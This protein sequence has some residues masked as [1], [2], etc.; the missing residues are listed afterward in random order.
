MAEAKLIK[1]HRKVNQSKKV[2]HR[3]SF[4]FDDEGQG[5]NQILYNKIDFD[6]YFKAI[7]VK[8]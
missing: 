3:Q 4:G 1:F 2:Y 5:H 6:N 7:E 8:L